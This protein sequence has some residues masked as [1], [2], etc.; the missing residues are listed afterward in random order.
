MK[1][2]LATSV[3]YLREDTDHVPDPDA[4]Y[5]EALEA[6]LPGGNA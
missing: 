2:Q 4:A 5:K 6:D 1:L 3:L